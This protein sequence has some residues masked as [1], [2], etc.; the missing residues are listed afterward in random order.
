MLLTTLCGTLLLRRAGRRQIAHF[1]VAVA[2]G[3]ITEIEAD[4]GGFVTARWS[5][6]RPKN[7]GKCPIAS[8]PTDSARRTEVR[9][10]LS[11]TGR[12]V[13]HTAPKP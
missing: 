13:S 9:P 7:G 6:L 4:S 8:C 5:I 2:D 10:F 11:G 1:R 12:H 3:R